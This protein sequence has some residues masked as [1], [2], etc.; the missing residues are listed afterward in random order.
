MQRDIKRDIMPEIKERYSTHYFS[1]EPVD[2]QDI[3]DILL[4]ATLAPSAYNEQPWRFYVAETPEDRAAILEYLTPGNAE[5]A[6]NAPV[7]IVVAGAIY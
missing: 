3:R 5:W 4:A 2:E 6:K 1:S 7:L